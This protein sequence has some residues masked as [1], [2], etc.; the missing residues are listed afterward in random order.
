MTQEVQTISRAGIPTLAVVIGIF[1]DGARLNGIHGRIDDLR[2]H[3]DRRLDDLKGTCISD[4]RRVQE[5]L[6]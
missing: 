2:S 5:R 1:V 4:L 6:R 3:L